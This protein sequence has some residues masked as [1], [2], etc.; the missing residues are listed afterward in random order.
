MMVALGM[1]LL[2]SQHFAN[3][4]GGY[5]SLTF[6]MKTRR[7]GKKNPENFSFFFFSVVSED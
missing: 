6:Y 4:E 3:V 1:L 2:Y 5:L 7:T